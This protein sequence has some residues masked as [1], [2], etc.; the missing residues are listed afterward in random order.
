MKRLSIKVSITA[1]LSLIFALFGFVGFAALDGMMKTDASANEIAT[2]WLPSVQQ[3]QQIALSLTNL[4]LAFRDHIIAQTPQEKA[5]REQAIATAEVQLEKSVAGYVPLISSTEEQSL[6]ESI[7]GDAAKYAAKRNELLALS[8]ANQTV[9]AGEFL[10]G[11]MKRFSDQAMTSA[12]E[13]VEVNQRG[14]LN[15]ARASAE[16]FQSARVILLA[17][18]VFALII[19]VGA[20]FNALVGIARPITGITQAMR[21]LAE[22]DT[23]SP[24]PYAGRTDEVGSMASAVEVF[25]LAA[26]ENNR[27][28]REAQV[29]RDEAERVRIALQG[30]AERDA[31]AR[32]RVATSG[33]AAGLQ[34]MASGDLAF[35]L[36]EPFSP[37][38]EA[39]RTDFNQSVH[40]LGSVLTAV[41]TSVNSIDASTREIASGAQDLSHRTEQQAASLEETA[42]A[43]EQIT[44]NV[45]ASSK[46][47]EEARAIATQA[48]DGAVKSTDV[49]SRAEA[50]MERIESSSQQISNIIGVIDEIAFQT[51]LLALNAGVEAARAG[52]AGKGFAV[53][54]QEVRELAQRSAQAAKEIKGLI[55][56]STEQVE[57][58]VTLVRNAGEALKAIGSSIA[59]MNAQM[60]SIATSS[61]EQNVGLGEVNSAVN[62]LDQTTQQNAAMVEQSTAAS[63]ALA[64]ESAKLRELVG[65]FLL[66]T[67]N[68]PS[69]RFEQP[70]RKVA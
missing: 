21:S 12:L 32:L 3:S 13:L 66:P 37:E 50:A 64:I 1:T 28:Q 60:E 43:L 18:V 49:V 61:R 15:A 16:T 17:A 39:L 11:E 23:S 41:A 27:L 4:R 35:Q 52:E 62:L 68:A 10:N 20:I 58:G 19:I 31:S 25:R 63:T 56:N 6:L 30:E 29:S 38:F 9:A 67:T 46:R 22:G 24:I 51:N 45:V 47:T 5:G 53:V 36:S 14:G 69:S 42:A 59:E 44:S 2:N 70:E 40:R 34:R 55:R 65:G 7:K 8:R 26:I 57:G 33:F 54:A 48:N